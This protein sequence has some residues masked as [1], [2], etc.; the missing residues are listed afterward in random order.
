MTTMDLIIMRYTTIINYMYA[1]E[2]NKN[3]S[4]F[5]FIYALLI[6]IKFALLS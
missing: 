5:L 1:L 3:K 2:Q 6:V 4:Y